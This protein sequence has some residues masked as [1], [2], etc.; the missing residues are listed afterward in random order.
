MVRRHLTRGLPR[1]AGVLAAGALALAGCAKD[2]ELLTSEPQ[3]TAVGA[4]FMER[5]VA[6]GNSI[7][8]GY[9]SGGI[10]DS[11]QKRSYPSLLA[12]TAGVRYAY[13]MLAGR[14][15]APPLTNF[16]TQARFT[17]PG[18]P[19]STSTTCDLR[20]GSSFT[21]TLNNVAVPGANSF[22]P[23]GLA[24]GG[25]SALTQFFLGGRSQVE[26]AIEANPTFAT[27]WIGNNDVLGFAAAGTTTGV[28]PEATF[29][30]NYA[31][32][33]DQL[34]AGSPDLERG[35]LIG[36]ADVTAIPLLVP[37][38]LLVPGSPIFN[39]QVRTIVETQLVG[40]PLQLLNCPVTTQALVAFPFF[41]ALRAQT[42]SLPASIPAPFA[43][44]P[45]TVPGVGELG[46]TGIL[47][48]TERAF[49][50]SRVAA[51]NAYIRAKADSIGFQYLDP[52]PTLLGWK[53]A[54]Q[55]PLFPRVTDA[56]AQI[57]GRYFSLDGVHPSTAG[58]A[59]FADTL[60]LRINR[61]YGA[62]LPAPDTLA[63]P[64]P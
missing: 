2:A 31:A 5:Y 28:T 54:G 56:P 41:A 46:T 8:A 52:N 57:F 48:E 26:R 22:D 29:R 11:T 3:A 39:Q 38:A 44:G 40:R 9:Q 51:Y 4:P 13:P 17:L 55:V 42:Q 43:C 33:I 20:A 37:A 24:G 62:N 35:V 23:T 27:V 49:F 6:L 45:I 25:Y 36:V 30:T 21:A 58:H 50:V 47:D 10:N 64:R 15:C 34:R 53:A 59:V 16:L 61:V 63:L 19:A 32:M 14:G 7:T 1:R 12:R 18:Q 60:R